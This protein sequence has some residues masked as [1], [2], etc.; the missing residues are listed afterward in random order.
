MY[1]IRECDI[2]WTISKKDARILSSQND[3]DHWIWLIR[4]GYVLM[5]A[6]VYISICGYMIYLFRELIY[7]YCS[8]SFPSL[9]SYRLKHFKNSSSRMFS[10]WT[11]FW[12]FTS[13]FDFD[14]RKVYSPTV[15][16]VQTDV[17]KERA[18]QGGFVR[19]CYGW[20]MK[21]C[22]IWMF[23]TL[24]VKWYYHDQHQ[25]LSKLLVQK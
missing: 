13:F 25:R 14:N 19:R 2:E 6:D 4:L 16:I 10:T 17:A 7:V 21:S 22:S 8:L 9:L 5:M 23:D 3:A 11:V 1:F 24:K 12:L 15:P 18:R 20:W